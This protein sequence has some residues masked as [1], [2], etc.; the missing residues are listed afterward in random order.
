VTDSHNIDTNVKALCEEVTNL[1]RI[2]DAISKSW[3]QDTLIAAAETGP[4]G[5]LWASVKAALEDCQGT[6]EQLLQKLN[7]VQKS[8]FVGRGILRRPVKNI[9]FNMRSKDILIFQQR[10]H[11]HS[12]AMQGGLQMIHLYVFTIFRWLA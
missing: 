10:V 6:L 12:I 1:S 2:A 9:K 8:N 3:K 11:S 4:H 5:N 7:E